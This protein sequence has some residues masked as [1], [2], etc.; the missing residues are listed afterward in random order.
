ML[1]QIAAAGLLVGPATLVACSPHAYFVYDIRKYQ[2]CKQIEKCYLFEQSHWFFKHL[3]IQNFLLFL[4]STYILK[5]ILINF[6]Y[7]K[8]AI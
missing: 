5:T 6:H 2:A 7:C 3:E 4:L 8:S 1:H